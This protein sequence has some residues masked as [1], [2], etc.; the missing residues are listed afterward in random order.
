MAGVLGTK[1]CENVCQ[2]Y[3]E[4]TVESGIKHHNPTPLYFWYIYYYVSHH[5]L[6]LYTICIWLIDV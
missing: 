1:F 4:N 6:M 2:C 3:N 5:M